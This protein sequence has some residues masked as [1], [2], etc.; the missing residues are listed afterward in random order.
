MWLLQQRGT[1]HPLQQHELA[2][3]DVD[4]PT[5]SGPSLLL[6]SQGFFNLDSWWGWHTPPRD[7]T[8][9]SPGERHPFTWSNGLVNVQ[10]ATQLT[11]GKCRQVTRSDAPVVR[12]PRLR[13]MTW[14]MKA[15]PFPQ[16]KSPTNR[17][18]ARSP[19]LAGGRQGE[20]P[21]FLQLRFLGALRFLS[22]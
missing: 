12:S 9:S 13:D 5:R 18:Q 2:A 11:A 20:P 17:A 4:M 19:E 21:W 22:I 14:P 7:L 15:V 10:P 16:L 8:W 6:W 1:S 3:H